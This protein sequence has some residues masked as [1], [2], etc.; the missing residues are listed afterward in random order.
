MSNGYFPTSTFEREFADYLAGHWESAMNQHP[1]DLATGV[2]LVKP[3]PVAAP[4]DD[5]EERSPF[6]P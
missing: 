4:V 1:N 2:S 5:E 6:L 3:Q